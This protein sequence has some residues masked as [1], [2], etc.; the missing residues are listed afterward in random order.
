MRKRALIVVAEL[1][2][3]MI[4]GF[5]GLLHLLPDAPASKA[6]FLNV[7]IGMTPAE[8]EDVLGG[9]P[10]DYQSDPEHPHEFTYHFA[11]PGAAKIEKWTGDEGLALVA[12]DSTDRVV[13]FRYVEAVTPHWTLL[14]ELRRW[15]HF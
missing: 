5:I 11:Y 8:V 6:R 9:P 12:Y 1:T 13:C 2:V 4:A 7:Q 10:G 14:A 3:V 15:C